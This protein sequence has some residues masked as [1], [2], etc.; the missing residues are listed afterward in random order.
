MK[1]KGGGRKGSF[2][3]RCRSFQDLERK[4][5]KSIH[6]SPE[7]KNAASE[8]LNC[9]RTRSYPTFQ[10]WCMLD[11]AWWQGSKCS[12]ALRWPPWL[13]P[14]LHCRIMHVPCWQGHIRAGKSDRIGSLVLTPRNLLNAFSPYQWGAR[15]SSSASGNSTAPSQMINGSG[16]SQLCTREEATIT[17]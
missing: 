15:L 8:T 3:G 5:V 6:K 7:K 10:G 4:K 16:A 12:L 11:A 2:V 1:D 14:P 17:S 9:F 13:L